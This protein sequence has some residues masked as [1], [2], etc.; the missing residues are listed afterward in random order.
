M[1]VL[2]VED[3][4]L[5]R[6]IIAGTL[7]DAGLKVA[8]AASAEEAMALAH[9]PPPAVLITDVDLGEGMGGL[10][11]GARAAD[12]WPDVGVLYI[13]GQSVLM[14]DHVLGPRERL[15]RKPFPTVALLRAVAALKRPPA[16]RAG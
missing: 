4:G 1:D 3:D 6:L 13:T 7:A 2:L 8:T 11:L 12:C 9:D 15:L 10:A 14:D 16:R 5:T